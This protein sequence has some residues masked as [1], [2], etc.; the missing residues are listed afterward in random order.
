MESSNLSR[1]RT[2]KNSRKSVSPIKRIMLSLLAVVTVL[3]GGMFWVSAEDTYDGERK[4]LTKVGPVSEDHG[5]PIWYKDSNGLRL[6]LCVDATDPLCDVPT[7]EMP[8]PDQAVSFPENFPGESFYMLAGA[9]LETASGERARAG[10]QLEAAFAQE[11][12]IDGDQIVFGRVRFRVDGI[13]TG[14]EYVITHPY[15]EDTFKAADDGEGVGEINYTQDIGIDGGFEKALESR[16]GTF[17]KWDPEYTDNPGE[18]DTNLPNLPAGYVG[19]PAVNNRIVGGLNNQN[20]V[21]IVGP[22]IGESNGNISPNRCTTE[23]AA[24]AGVSRADCIIVHE[25]SLMGKE[26]TIA[27]LDVPRA[28]YS[29][30]TAGEG[31][32]DV[33]AW[34]EDGEPKQSLE[35]SVVGVDSAPVVMDGEK[36]HYFARVAYTAENPPQVKVSNVTDN[37]DSEKVITPVDHITATAEYDVTSDSLKVIAKSSDEVTPPELK[38]KELGVVIPADGIIANPEVVLPNITVTSAVG[39]KVTIPVNVVGGPTV[40]TPPVANA[41]TDVE[42]VV[43]NPVTL[44]GSNTGTGEV[45]VLWEQVSPDNPKVVLSGADTLNPTFTPTSPG[46][47]VFKM[48]LTTPEGISSDEVTIT[49][50]STEPVLDPVAD[51]GVAKE[52]KQGTTVTLDGSGSTN[53]ADYQWTQIDDGTTQVTLDLTN[54]AKPTFKAPKKAEK[55]TFE[56]TAVNANGVKHTDRVTITVLP[57]NLTTTVAE[58]DRRKRDWRIEGTSDV[59]GPGVKITIYL[60]TISDANK[61]TEVQVDNLGD[62]I[63]R[64]AGR[65]ALTGANLTLVSSSGG[66]LTVPVTVR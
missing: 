43:G 23:E 52:V 14:A 37:P 15:G 64:G 59:F 12:V 50:T 32:I 3:G 1:K 55:L 58:Y 19:D 28:T 27:G 56:L 22:G 16:I 30:T 5:F 6:E 24:A 25:F 54:P 61:L 26:A 11:E 38:V 65:A 63:Y 42:V 51:A 29:R 60:G 17:I 53:T 7:D 21:R 44:Q 18:P 45:T 10:F 39:G 4:Y 13:Q 66:T 49:V 8:F 62:W 33:F 35:V 36:G 20:F 41:G 57:D 47:Y 34:S 40:S 48:T 46:T 2:N 31:T 9:E